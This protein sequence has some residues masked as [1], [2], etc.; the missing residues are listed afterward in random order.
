MA[1][2]GR[3]GITPPPPA[4]FFGLGDLFSVGK[5]LVGG[6]KKLFGGDGG[7]QPLATGCPPGFQLVQGNCVQATRTPGIVGAAQRIVPGGA[8]GFEVMGAGIGCPSGFHPNKSS[9]M[10]QAGFVEKGTRCVRNRRRNNLNPRALRRAG[11]R[12]GGFYGEA[13]KIDKVLKKSVRKGLGSGRR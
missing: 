3:P 13:I 5:T 8:T 6:A 4:A 2:L 11:S 12:I 1:T 9:Y 10:T 7:A